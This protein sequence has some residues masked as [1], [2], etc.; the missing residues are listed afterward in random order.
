MRSAS[1]TAWM[2]IGIIFAGAVFWLVVI[3]VAG[4]LH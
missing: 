3:C 2:D 1:K 4:L